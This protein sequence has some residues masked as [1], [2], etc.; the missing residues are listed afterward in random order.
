MK[1]KK[2]EENEKIVLSFDIT[3]GQVEK[4]K[5][6]KKDLP[7]KKFGTID[8][9]YTYCFTPNGIGESLIVKRSDEFEI[10]LTDYG[11]WQLNKVKKELINNNK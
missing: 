5:K 11:T 10:D 8:F 3:S 1:N 6:W 9:G 4:L 2:E 7:K